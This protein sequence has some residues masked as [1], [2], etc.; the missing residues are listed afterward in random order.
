MSQ[1]QDPLDGEISVSARLEE[2][3]LTAAAKSR[4]LMALDRLLGNL[5]D[6][7]NPFLERISGDAREKN[8]ARRAVIKAVGDAAANEAAEDKDI[9]RAFASSIAT[10]Q[11]DKLRNKQEVAYMAIEHLNEKSGEDDGPEGTKADE[12]NIDQDWI[13]LFANYAER[14]SSQSLKEM[15]ARVLANEV[16]EP[17]SF[18]PITLR[19]ISELSRDSALLFEKYVGRAF[20]MHMVKSPAARGQELVDLVQLEQLGFISGADG[21]VNLELKVPDSGIYK[22]R[23]KEFLV[24]GKGQPG[25]MF[26]IH[27]VFL[28]QAAQQ[29][30]PIL[31]LVDYRQWAEVFA[32]NLTHDL[33]EV[34][35][36]LLDGENAVLLKKLN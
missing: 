20:G 6:L 4:F 25:L 7:P 23:H 13:N 11:F 24:Q 8:E 32:E 5:L 30:L 34:S 35:I 27:T 14:A 17:G 1:S 33:T 21:T 29:I 9:A 31:D 22:V 2:S 16:I 15:W 18:A 19:V 12:K 28:T 36:Y 26:R 3:G 10:E